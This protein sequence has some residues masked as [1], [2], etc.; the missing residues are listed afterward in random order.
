MGR[1]RGTVFNWLVAEVAG[2][3]VLDLFAGTGALAF[4]ALSRGAASATLV[5]RDRVVAAQLRAE[6][7]RLDADCEVLT[8]SARTWL[9]RQINWKWDLVFV[10]PPFRSDL[11]SNVMSLLAERNTIVY[12]EQHVHDTNDFPA[13]DTIKSGRAGEARFRLLRSRH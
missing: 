8:V 11:A 10:D 4:E 5:E 13:W 6:A 9:E 2:A 7:A 12:L 1:V 3:R